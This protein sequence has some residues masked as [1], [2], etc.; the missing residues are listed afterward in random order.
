MNRRGTRVREYYAYALIAG[1]PLKE[2]RRMMPG[3]IIDMFKLRAEY[4]IKVSG[5]TVQKRRLL[6]G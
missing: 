4:D 2:A 1:I 6:G 3:F 5:G